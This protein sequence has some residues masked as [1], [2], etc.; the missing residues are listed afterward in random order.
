MLPSLQCPEY[1]NKYKVVD[2]F[3]GLG[4]LSLG[5]MDAGFNVVVSVDNWKPAINLHQLNFKHPILDLD[6]NDTKVVID[7]LVAFDPSIIIGGPP[8]QD[9]SS[10]GKR[11]DNGERADLTLSFATIVAKIKPDFFVMENVDRIT[12]SPKFEKAKAIFRKAKYGLTIQ[13]LDASLCGVPQKRKRC[14]VVGA[15]GAND[16]FLKSYIDNKIL[17]Q[18]MNVKNYIPNI[19]VDFYYRHPRTYNRR[20]IFSVNEPSP[21]IRGVNRPIPETYKFHLQDATKDRNKVRPLTTKERAL[22]QTFPDTFCFGDL[23]K[24]NLE[25]LIGNAVPVK[26]AHFVAERLKE[27]IYNEAK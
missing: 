27:H 1:L 14:F 5:F 24:G 19:D 13:V 21:T 20:A 11:D 9:F 17:K 3:S 23:K 7:N 25:Q 26:L 16:D 22:I 8:C 10:A 12:K 18:E 2:L 4:G 15:I 6:L